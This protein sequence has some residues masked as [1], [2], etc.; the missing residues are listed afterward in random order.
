[1]SVPRSRDD[2]AAFARR[3]AYPVVGKGIDPSRPQGK[4]KII[5]NRPDELL[6]TY[7]DAGTVSPPNFMLQEY[8]PG[9]DETG[10]TFYGY[11][12]ESSECLASFSARKIRLAPAYTGVI[13]L[14]VTDDNETVQEACRKFMKGAG[15][16]GP[17]N[18]GGKFD[19][20]DGQYKVLDVNARL[21]ASF[22]LCLSEAGLDVVRVLYLHLTGQRVSA[23]H[24]LIGRRWLLEEDLFA[25]RRYV[26]DGRLTYGQ[27]W[28]SLR[29]V[30]EC[31]WWAP[32]DPKPFVWWWMGRMKH[33][34]GWR[35]GGRSGDS[36]G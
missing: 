24:G 17:V 4:M 33:S 15:Y 30:H 23:Q 6:A 34:L 31:A 2:V 12:D 29:G 35:R 13:S 26:R 10:W 22:R 16:R 1:V 21:G 18:I 9:D 11:F 14:G 20:R 3:A 32:D 28:R 7:A 5:A 25:F 8:I 19:R 36:T 27:W